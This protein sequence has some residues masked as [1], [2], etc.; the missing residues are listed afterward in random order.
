MTSVRDSPLPFRRARLTSVRCDDAGTT[1]ADCIEG[2]TPVPAAYSGLA[3]R[4]APDRTPQ[5]FGAL[6]DQTSRFRNKPNPDGISSR[7]RGL[8]DCPNC[9]LRGS[10]RLM[11]CP[12]TSGDRNDRTY[13]PGSTGGRCRDD[14]YAALDVTCA[15]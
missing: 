7:I 15:R 12:R 14:A 2:L 10:I 6:R 8:K 5:P 11:Q 1:A 9:R 4:A 13:S 3:E